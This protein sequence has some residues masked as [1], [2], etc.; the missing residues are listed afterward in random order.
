MVLH[1]PVSVAAGG[2]VLRRAGAWPVVPR[3]AV[4]HRVLNLLTQVGARSMVLHLPVS[5]AVGGDRG[6]GRAGGFGHYRPRSV[7]PAYGSGIGN[8]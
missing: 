5:V 1:L 6:I 8:G 4:C 7:E 3:R 2:V